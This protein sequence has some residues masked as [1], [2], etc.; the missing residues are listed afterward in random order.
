MSELFSFGAWVRQRRRALDLTRDELAAQIGCAVTT[1]RHIETDERRP[2]KQLAARLAECLQLSA[3]ERPAFLQAARGGLAVD[4]LAA[5]AAGVDWNIGGIAPAERDTGPLP[6]P[7]GTVTFLFTDIEA[8]TQLWIQNAQTMGPAIARHEAILHAVITAGGGVVFKTVGDA[9]YAAFAS[10]LDAVQAAVEGQRAIAV[11]P[12]GTSTPLSVR[13]ALHSGVVEERGGDYF[14]LPLSRSAGLLA[15]SH[16]GQILL[17]QATQV[18]VRE[19]LSPELTLRHLGRYQLKDLSDPQHIFQLLAPDLVADFPPLRLSTERAV[20]EPRLTLPLFL[21]AAPSQPSPAAPFVA[22]EQEVTALATALATARSG[23]GQILFVIGEAGRGKTTLVQEFARQAQAADAELLVVSGSCNAHT[24]SGD[25][26]LPF[27][28]ALTMLSGEVEAR[29]AGG[30]ITTEHARR[31]WEAM[32]LTLPALVEHAPDLLGTFVPGKGLRERAATVATPDA[33]WF[34]ELVARASAEAGA[35]VAQQPILAQYSAALN[36]IARQ[37]PLLLILEDLHWV[38]TAS[39]DLLL[40]LSREAAHSRMLILGTYRPDELAVSHGETHHPLAELV[41]ELK[42]QHGDIWLDLGELA[43]ADGR[44]FVEAYLD[45]QPN[46]LGPAFREALFART[47]GHALFTVELVREL[48]E[49]GDVKDEAGQWIE[50]PAINWN[51]LPARVEGAIEK[52]IQRLEQELRSILTIASVEGETFTAEVVARVQ[53]VQERG[54]V[55]RLSQEL[56]KQHRLVTAHILAWL[57]PQRLSLYRFR[58]QLFQQ[59]VY[60]SLAAMERAYLH[61][62]VGSVLEALYGAQTEPIAVQLARHF[63][64]AGLTAKA[65]TYLLQAGRRAARLSA[66]QEVIAHVSKALALLERLPET[67]ERAQTELELQIALGT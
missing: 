41:S 28:E 34:R 17:S 11:E 33:P 63:E 58:H 2:S 12:W 31:L 42:R 62:A 51:V 26:Y 64:L 15:A 43:E 57:G 55:Q 13:M 45:T 37:R 7:S 59:Y 54:L 14:G 22:R 1:I 19:Q 50:G 46:R 25:P 16:G 56:D 67:P 27:R 53:Q 3:D 44:H 32:P 35:R 10:A 4:R 9:L 20:D 21:T 29:W 8:S 52:R 23:A 30:L 49:R 38:D 48:Q 40:H 6:L 60:H 65:I 47:G 36:A 66:N 61:E 5:P 18:L 24:G 39:S